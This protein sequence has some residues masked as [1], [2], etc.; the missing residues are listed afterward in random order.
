MGD[1]SAFSA[2]II[3]RGIKFINVPTTLLAQVDSSVGGKTGINNKFGKNLIGTF[4]QP[5]LVITDIS[6]LKSLSRREIICGYAEILKH[7]LIMNKNFFKWLNK[8][9]K[10]IINLQNENILRYA[11]YESCKIKAKIVKKDENEKNLRQIL[12]FGHTFAHAFEATKNFSKIINH[13][14]AVLMGIICAS[15]FANLNKTMKNNDLSII[16]NHYNKLGL[17]MNLKK[18]FTKKDINKIL[19]FMKTDKKNYNYKIN[20]VLLKKIGNSIKTMAFNE[21]EVKKYLYKKLS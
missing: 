2:S 21:N 14:E 1:I 4:Y 11:I 9:G 6:L 12:N 5:D 20:L 8:N 13:G 15:E 18:Y 7:S 17:N 10:K 16:K 19:F 3:K